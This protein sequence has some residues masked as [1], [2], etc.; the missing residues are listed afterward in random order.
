MYKYVSLCTAVRGD[1]RAYIVI[2]VTR[3]RLVKLLN[4]RIFDLVTHCVRYNN[5]VYLP[6]L[7]V[8]T[9]TVR[10]SLLLLLLYPL[11]ALSYIYVYITLSSP[12]R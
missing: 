1:G 7:Y 6:I 2:I 8:E 10:L 5:V 12:K 9:K 3:S 11:S 4:A